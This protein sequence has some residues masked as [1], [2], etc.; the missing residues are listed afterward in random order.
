MPSMLS[1]RGLLRAGLGG[2]ALLAGAGVAARVVATAPFGHSAAG[3]AS[4]AATVSRA[5]SPI[6]S[7]DGL[8]IVRG[9][10]SLAV[11]V[12]DLALFAGTA[13]TDTDPCPAC[14]AGSSSTP[15]VL[16]TTLLDAAGADRTEPAR[17]T[18]R[19][20]SGR[21]STVVVG[22]ARVRSAGALVTGH[23]HRAGSSGS[24]ARFSLLGIR[25]GLDA[26]ALERIEVLA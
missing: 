9:T 1:R 16:L 11:T 24:A 15:R 19:T 10:T 7:T 4:S 18:L 26:A 17:L 5:G 2:G 20:T 13:G 6:A 23:R 22:A 14:A 25:D 12:A 21:S 3:P 8:Q